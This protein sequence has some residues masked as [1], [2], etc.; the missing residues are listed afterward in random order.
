[1]GWENLVDHQ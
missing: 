1:M